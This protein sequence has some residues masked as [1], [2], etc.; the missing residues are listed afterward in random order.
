MEVARLFVR[1]E[2]FFFRL[3]KIMI[4]LV[5]PKGQRLGRGRGK[6]YKMRTHASYHEYV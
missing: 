1:Y 2:F 5:L 6:G 3:K 4:P